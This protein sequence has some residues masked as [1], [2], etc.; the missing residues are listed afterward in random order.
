MNGKKNKG[1]KQNKMQ[2]HYIKN[3]NNKGNS[4]MADQLE[5]GRERETETEREKNKNEPISVI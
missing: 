3:A 4:K 1:R 2:L 5:R